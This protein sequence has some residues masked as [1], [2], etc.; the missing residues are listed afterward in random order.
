MSPAS[1]LMNHNASCEQ[2]EKKK[3]RLLCGKHAKC[4]QKT[5]IHLSEKEARLR[6]R[7]YAKIIITCVFDGEKNIQKK[8]MIKKK[9]CVHLQSVLHGSQRERKSK[10]I[11]EKEERMKAKCKEFLLKILKF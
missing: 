9:T 1:L 11:E 6:M 5:C 3:Q 4:I 7:S 8:I 10:K 2:D